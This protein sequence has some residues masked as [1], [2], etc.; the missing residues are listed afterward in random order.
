MPD[1]RGYSASRSEG[2]SWCQNTSPDSMLS[3]I[4]S[5]LRRPATA[6]T[7]LLPV[8]AVRNPALRTA[9]ESYPCRWP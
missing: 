7:D 3:S 1:V 2:S 5:S 8:K 6:A 4:R 9:L